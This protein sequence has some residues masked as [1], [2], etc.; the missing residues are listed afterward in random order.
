MFE[1]HTLSFLVTL[2]FALQVIYVEW[3]KVLNL[4]EFSDIMLRNLAIG[5]KITIYF[6]EYP[7][8]N[9]TFVSRYTQ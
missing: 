7:Q 1:V 9:A 6:Y 5:V 4:A 2:C 3:I 8:K